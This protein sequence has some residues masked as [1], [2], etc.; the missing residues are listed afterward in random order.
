MLNLWTVYRMFLVKTTL[1]ASRLRDMTHC[2]RKLLLSSFRMFWLK[3]IASRRINIM[4]NAYTS[5]SHAEV[6]FIVFF[7][8]RFG[9]HQT[10]RVCFERRYNPAFH[11]A[12]TSLPLNTLV[13]PQTVVFFR[14]IQ[15]SSHTWRSGTV[16]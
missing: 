8:C 5:N 16:L 15:S 12:V 14:S 10:V 13:F 3:R 7:L 11:Y 6:S 2:F 9:E 4:D 1:Y